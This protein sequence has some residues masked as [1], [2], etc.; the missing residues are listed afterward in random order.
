M[1][2]LFNFSIIFKRLFLTSNSEP[3]RPTLNTFVESHIMVDIPSL[4]ISFNLS[5][6]IFD[7]TS[8]S[9]SYF[10]S[11]VCKIFEFGVLIYKPFGSTIECVNETNSIL[12]G[13]KSKFPPNGTIFK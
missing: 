9:G 3:A 10:Q 2:L 1:T 12:N 5:E 6:L 11:P 7:P 13:F 4:P 8:G